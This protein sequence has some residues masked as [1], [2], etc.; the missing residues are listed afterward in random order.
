MF[1]KFVIV[2]LT[3][4]GFL[5]QTAGC[6]GRT[7]NNF[8]LPS[9]GTE[10]QKN[11]AFL[12]KCLTTNIFQIYYHQDDDYAKRIAKLLHHVY[13]EFE[14][15]ASE[16][17][18]KL[19][20]PDEKL[21]WLCFADEN[22]FESYGLTADNINL[23]RL[24]GYYSTKTNRVAVL[25]SPQNP[26]R[27]AQ[28]TNTRIKGFITSF[29]AGVL[30]ESG[31]NKSEL[32][33]ISHELAHQLSFNCG[34]QK[35]DVAYPLWVSEGLSTSF[36]G[37]LD[38]ARSGLDNYPRMRRLKDMTRDNRL[39]DLKKF[40]VL[41]EIELNADQ[42]CQDIYAQACG[43]YTFISNQYPHQFKNYLTKRANA[44]TGWQYESVL[45]KDFKEA[46]GPIDKI[47][48]QWQKFCLN[49]N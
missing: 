7:Q 8:T 48:P 17:G 5:L 2:V 21:Q 39:I 45:L 41:S 10:T 44:A 47:Q 35:R 23:S 16:I 22:Q 32:K 25:T 40:I 30:L 13:N 4:T 38:G 43:F 19:T 37:V 29:D 3:L 26:N 31:L 34:I 1:R 24:G 12:D 46:F 9:T 18:I 28:N 42:T 11:N 36:E 27:Q 6:Y 20:P 33:R 15:Q 49:L 14:K